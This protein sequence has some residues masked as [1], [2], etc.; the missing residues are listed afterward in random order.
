MSLAPGG[1][2]TTFGVPLDVGAAADAIGFDLG[3]T[4]S[5][6]R[7]IGSNLNQI[8]GGV[9]GLANLFG[10]TREKKGGSGA[11]EFDTEAVEEATETIDDRASDQL[12][13]IMD[14]FNQTQNAY[15]VTTADAIQDYYTRFEDV[16]RDQ[17]QRGTD[18]LENF[19]PRLDPQNQRLGQ[20][21]D[22]A[23]QQYGLQYSPAL[24]LYSKV[25]EVD[26]SKIYGSLDMSTKGYNV[27][28][29]LIRYDDPYSQSLMNFGDKQ[30]AAYTTAMVDPSGPG[31]ALMQYGV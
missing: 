4:S 8:L 14:I 25:I 27:A 19:D 11:F 18:K 29:P 26:P 10:S 2:D 22:S 12:D 17:F 23:R 15:G 20:T 6:G 28:N 16:I 5:N 9:G 30:L 7:S 3:A 31:Q 1:F 21:I 24:D 13:N